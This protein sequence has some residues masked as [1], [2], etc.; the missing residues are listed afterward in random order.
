[1]FLIGGQGITE[2]LSNVGIDSTPVGVSVSNRIS[3]VS[4]S[5]VELF[6]MLRTFFE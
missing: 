2:E 4:A 3:V 6:L 5:K 1:M